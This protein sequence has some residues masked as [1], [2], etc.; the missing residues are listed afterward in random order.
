MLVAVTMAVATGRR[1]RSSSKEIFAIDSQ[2]VQPLSTRRRPRMS[3]IVVARF[4]ISDLEAAKQS[5]RDG[6]CVTRRDH[7]TKQ[8]GIQHHR[9]TEGIGEHVGIDEWDRI[10]SFQEIFR[11][12]MKIT[13]VTEHAGAQ[14]HPVVAVVREFAQYIRDSAGDSV[15]T[16]SRDQ[17]SAAST[18]SVGCHCG[19][20]L[21][22]LFRHSRPRFDGDVRD[23][24]EEEIAAP[25]TTGVDVNGEQW[26]VSI[27][28][29]GHKPDDA[30]MSVSARAR[31]PRPDDT[32]L[33]GTGSASSIRHISTW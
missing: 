8:S 32:A 15:I 29:D 20:G 24:R 18:V 12:R 17:R 19:R 13:Q 27:V 14:G 1:L 11:R 33:E 31:L 7:D 9:F 28:I 4:T 23:A 5:I 25:A 30:D 6:R 16:R 22:A 3:V 21:A 10:E 26:S 2:T